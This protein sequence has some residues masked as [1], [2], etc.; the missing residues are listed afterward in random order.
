MLKAQKL[1]ESFMKKNCKKNQ[2]NKQIKNVSISVFQ[3]ISSGES[4]KVE[5]DL[6]NY[7]SK[8]D[9]KNAT[10]VDTSKFAKKVDLASLISYVDK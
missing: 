3:K 6:S 7:A 1:L 8:A 10:G 2:T 4:V 9:M 5:L